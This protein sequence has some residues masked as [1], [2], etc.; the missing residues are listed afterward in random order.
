[1]DGSLKIIKMKI[2]FVVIHILGLYFSYA[3]LGVILNLLFNIFV[4]QP[5]IINTLFTSVGVLLGLLV[6]SAISYITKN[7]FSINYYFSIWYLTLWTLVILK[8]VFFTW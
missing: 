8:I 5:K 6:M 3:A 1:M 7:K 4:P 2:L